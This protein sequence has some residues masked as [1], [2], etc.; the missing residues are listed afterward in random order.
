MFKNEE[1]AE[2]V[3]R[4]KKGQVIL[5]PTDTVWGFGCDAFNEEACVRI[6]QIKNRGED[7][8]FII[9]VSDE[10]MLSSY[11]QEI[12]P[13]ISLILEFHERPITIVYD[14]VKKLPNHLKAQDGSVAIR[15]VKD[16]FCQAF[17]KGLGRP[18][19]STSANYSGD[20]TPRNFG[21]MNK[22][23]FEEVD[24]VVLHNQDKETLNAAS[25]LAKFSS[26]GELTILRS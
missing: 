26:K 9:L 16:P 5:C 7:K 12:L 10:E 24:Y 21:E 4:L 1:I 25:V 2:V 19:V 6:N 22:M 17:I 11:V 3:S 20:P 18:I 13:K 23:I 15:V 8:S 14:R